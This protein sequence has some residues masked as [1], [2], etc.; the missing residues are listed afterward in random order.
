MNDATRK[1]LEA[2]GWR[3]MEDDGGWL[4][5]SHDLTGVEVQPWCNG[6]PRQ[7]REYYSTDEWL[8]FTPEQITVL[9]ALV[10]AFE[11]EGKE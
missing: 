6:K 11:P 9:R 7:R 3:S 4:L 10:E 2:A 5:L 1:R 8:P